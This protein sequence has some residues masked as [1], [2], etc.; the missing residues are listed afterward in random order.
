MQIMEYSTP[1]EKNYL[2][3]QPPKQMKRKQIQKTD[4]V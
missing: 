2:T 1:L 3:G 4:M